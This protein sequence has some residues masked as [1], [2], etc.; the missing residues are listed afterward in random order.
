MTGRLSFLRLRAADQWLA[1]H[2]D[3]GT[4]AQTAVGR[5]LDFPLPGRESLSFRFSPRLRFFKIYLL[6]QLVILEPSASTANSA[7]P[8]WQH[9]RRGCVGNTTRNSVIVNI[10]SLQ[11]RRNRKLRGLENGERLGSQPLTLFWASRPNSSAAGRQIRIRKAVA[12]S[13][14]PFAIVVAAWP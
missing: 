6:C 13:T 4:G 14:A 2:P 11:R 9:R 7:L 5:C 3:P 1:S 10:L 12:T 8:R